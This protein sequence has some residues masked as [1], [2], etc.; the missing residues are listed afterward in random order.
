MPR[1]VVS[2]KVLKHFVYQIFEKSGSIDK[3]SSVCAEHLV[4]ANLCGVDTHGIWQVPGYLKDIEKKLL[5]P[6]AIPT[7]IRDLGSVALV[8]GEWTFGQV[9][10]EYALR[11]GIKRLNDIP[12][13]LMGIVKCHHLGR[14]GYYTE[15]AAKYNTI[16]ILCGGGYGV[17]YP[18]TV[19]FGG[20]EKFFNTNPL[21]TAFPTDDSRIMS[22]FA[23]TEGANAKVKIASESGQDLPLGFGV[24]KDGNP[25]TDPN[26]I[27]SG[28]A[29]LPFGGHK[30]YSIMVAVEILTRILMGA[31]SY[32]EN[33]RG[34]SVYGH[35]GVFLLLIK[36]DIFRSI[37]S[38][39]TDV[40]ELINQLHAV[41]P[42]PGFSEVLVPGD[43]EQRKRKER[44]K[45]GIPIPDD[46]WNSLLE[47]A[48]NL[49]I[50]SPIIS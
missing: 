43:P 9:A 40:K 25:T 42:A 8:S 32:S 46:V 38:F 21:S 22:D 47:I 45:N 37:D 15:L 28:G 19:P 26:K 35:Q 33:G 11:E 16:A 29:L 1:V 18:T 41:K 4:D 50:E 49:D 36:P 39:F 27:I 17:G 10:A 5:I 44:R 7:I 14:V 2:F 3:N 31:D 48:R 12:I 13:V 24:D 30:G 23:T 6:D 34:G 20:R